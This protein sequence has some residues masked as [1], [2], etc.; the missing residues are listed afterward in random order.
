MLEN[1][2][3]DQDYVGLLLSFTLVTQP[4]C[5]WQALAVLQQGQPRWLQCRATFL[6][7]LHSSALLTGALGRNLTYLRA[8]VLKQAYSVCRCGACSAAR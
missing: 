3:T 1:V 4:Q 8:L 2:L 7:L 5:I 6:Q